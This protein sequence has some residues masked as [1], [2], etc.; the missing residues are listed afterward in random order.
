MAQFDKYL[1]LGTVNGEILIVESSFFMKRS[2]EPKIQIRN[3]VIT[4]SAITGLV[5]RENRLFISSEKG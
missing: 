2:S 1:L 5:V 3:Y 4:D